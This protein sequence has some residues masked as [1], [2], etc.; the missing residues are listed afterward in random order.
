[1]ILSFYN[2]SFDY[3][4][5]MT[6]EEIDTERGC[7]LLYLVKILKEFGVKA[8]GYH[9]EEDEYGS[10]LQLTPFIANIKIISGVFHYIVVFECRGDDVIIGDPSKDYMITISRGRFYKLFTGT[11]LELKYVCE[12]AL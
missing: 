1:M 7:N 5:L 2:I 11:F 12:K 8:D 10:V 3:D 6:L 4:R 9:I